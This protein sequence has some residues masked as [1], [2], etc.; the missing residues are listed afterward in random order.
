VDGG[1]IRGR[2]YSAHQESL[3]QTRAMLG[4]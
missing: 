2:A 4:I 3:K 1:L